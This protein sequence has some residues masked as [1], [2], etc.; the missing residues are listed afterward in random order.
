MSSEVYPIDPNDLINLPGGSSADEDEKEDY[1]TLLCGDESRGV[2]DS[3]LSGRLRILRAIENGDEFIPVRVAFVPRIPWWNPFPLFIRAWRNYYVSHGTGIYHTDPSVL[4]DLGIERGRRTRETAYSFTRVWNDPREGG[5]ER[6]DKLA[7]SI[8]KDGWN[9]VYRLEIMLLRQMGTQDNLNDGHHRMS[10][11][12]TYGIKRAAVRFAF[13]GKSP[14][15][16]QLLLRP[17]A[18]LIL[19]AKRYV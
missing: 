3:L 14:G 5:L 16:L 2:P 18:R 11:C 17:L 13:A 7:S 10:I 9:D 12:L 6:Y 19:R 8:L 15:W 4:R 1:V